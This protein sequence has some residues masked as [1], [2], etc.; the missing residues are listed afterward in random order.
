MEQLMLPDNGGALP[1]PEKKWN[2]CHATPTCMGGRLCP[3]HA[4]EYDVPVEITTRG[5]YR[6][7]A[8]SPEQAED[9]ASLYAEPDELAVASTDTVSGTAV[10]R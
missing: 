8:T 1:A 2:A 10:K 9:I 5:T 7:R 3:E 4:V 6:L